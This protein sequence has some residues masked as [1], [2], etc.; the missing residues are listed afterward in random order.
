MSKAMRCLRSLLFAVL[1]L[2]SLGCV[3]I[4]T[5]PLGEQPKVCES[6]EGAVRVFRGKPGG[7]SYTELA[8][9]TAQ[10]A[11]WAPASWEDLLR[12]M[13]Q[14]AA[15]LGANAIIN[16][17]LGKLDYSLSLGPVGSG[18]DTREL[19]GVAVRLE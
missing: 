3:R 19:T 16:L 2:Q 9:V 11:W 1:V 5:L 7:R 15:S 13:C 17:T 4:S 14:E 10:T 6:N 12:G 18:G 8:I